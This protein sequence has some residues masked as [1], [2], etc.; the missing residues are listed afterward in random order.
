VG[1]KNSFLSGLCTILKP[2]KD[3]TEILS[4]EKYPTFSQALP[5][6]RTFENFESDQD[7]FNEDVINR[8]SSHVDLRT[9]IGEDSFSSTVL[10]LKN[11]QSKI[12]KDFT[13][14]FSEMDLTIL[15][16]ANEEIISLFYL[17]IAFE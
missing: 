10:T 3:V 1:K 13:E 15:S 6:L 2:F 4:G 14:R 12:L 8:K 5:L 7:L 9:Y 11:Y 16:V 17:H